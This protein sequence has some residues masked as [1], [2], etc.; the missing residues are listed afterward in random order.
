MSIPI[1]ATKLYFPPLRPKIVARPALIAKI[2]EGLSAGRKLTLISAPAG[3]GKTTIVSEWA[4]GCGR[5]AAWLSLDEEDTGPT[6]FLTY[7]VR[8]LQTIDADIGAGVLGMLQD[9]QSPPIELILTTLLNEI[10]AI[11]KNF[12]FVLDDYHMLDSKE[13][14]NALTFLLEHQPS[15][16]HL[17]ITS[18]EDPNLP[19]ARLRVRGQLTELRAA[20]LRFSPSEAAEFLN[21][22]MGLTLSAEDIAALETRTEGW[23]AGLQLAALSMQGHKDVSGF[24]QEFTGDHRY[25]VDYL[26]EEVLKRQPESVRS[27]LLQTAI[28]ECLNGPLCEAVTGQPGGMARLETLQRGNFFL[29]P[30]DDKRHWYRYHHLFADVLHLHLLAEQSDQV[31][32][33]HRRASEWYEQ[34]GSPTDAIRHAMAGRDFER[35]ADLVELTFQTMGR[36]RQEA[37]LLGWLKALPE[38][39]IR[40]RPVLCNLYAG[41]LMQTGEIQGVE[42]WLLAAE[43]WMTMT[44]DGRDWPEVAFVTMIVADQEEFRRLPGAV[45]VHRA[46]LALLH[47]NVTSTMQYARQALGLAPEDDFL[48]RGG[49]A[50]LLGLAYWTNG[51]LEAAQRMYAEGMAWLRQA[52]N[53]S[54]VIGCTIALA[55]ITIAQGHLHEAIRTY[56]RALQLAAEH[57]TPTMRGTADML[58]GMSELYR[59]QNDLHAASQYLHR[60]KEQGEHTGLPQNLYRWRAALARIRLAEGDLDGALDLLIEAERLY[61][62]DFSPNVRPIPALKTRVWLAQGKLEEALGWVR[63]HGLSAQDEISYLREFEH[64]TLARVLLAGYKCDHTDTSIRDAIGLLERL[65]AAAQKGGRMGIVI[66]VLGLQALAHQAQGDILAALKPL[67]QALTLAEPEGYIRLFLDEGPPMIQLLRE[68]AARKIMPD[69]TGRLLAGF[70]AEG[71]SSAGEASPRIIPASQ[72]LIEPLSLREL[73]ILRLFKTELSGPEIAR[74]LVIALSTVRT[75]TKSIFGKLNVNNRRAAVKRAAELSLI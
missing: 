9:P 64:I 52:G 39:L 25:I 68:A 18:R 37:T 7:L 19:L 27:F 42:T 55:D 70:E 44:E 66:E 54:D 16:M 49:A 50:G 34:N 5:P 17:V 53:I 6:R 14:D 56:E 43:R 74:E 21:R 40:N 69:Y 36:N 65:L 1:L 33:L 60:S 31:P 20:D 30:L 47:G 24:I 45:A 15:Q 8:A 22:M 51:D 72:H 10:S 29:I 28:L 57:G 63:K 35:A 62:G 73:E 13:V 46:G 38:L 58:V 41:I 71:H 2:N 75:H 26:V 4:A 23:I 3:F 32:A 59:E 11:P 67:Q 48:R 12:I 61:V